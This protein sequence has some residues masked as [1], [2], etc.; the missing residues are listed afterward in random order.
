MGMLQL[1]S[2]YGSV[3][4]LPF[5]WQTAFPI[6][7]S[8]GYALTRSVGWGE[9]RR[10]RWRHVMRDGSDLRWSLETTFISPHMIGRVIDKFTR[11]AQR[12]YRRRNHFHEQLRFDYHLS[13]SLLLLFFLLVL[14]ISLDRA[15][16]GKRNSSYPKST[17]LRRMKRRKTIG[18]WRE[19]SYYNG[20]NRIE[21]V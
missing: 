8:G 4:D 21:D 16:L 6:S 10:S 18:S 3:D 7:V 15:Q 20:E 11:P 19:E 17:E 1:S 5:F 14:T 13:N 12:M 2:S 9:L